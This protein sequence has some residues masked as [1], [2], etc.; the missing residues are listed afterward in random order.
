MKCGAFGI[1]VDD[2]QFDDSTPISMQGAKELGR[3]PFR[4]HFVRLK[5]GVREYAS[6]DDRSDGEGGVQ[7]PADALILF[8]MLES[9]RAFQR[10]PLAALVPGPTANAYAM[11]IRTMASATSG[12]M[13]NNARTPT[14]TIRA[15]QICRA[16]RI[17]LPV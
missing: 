15:N 4:Q 14:A 13:K 17:E 7:S 9:K 5:S 1:A 3:R 2:I 8:P 6:F 16:Q 10:R 11:K 12:Q